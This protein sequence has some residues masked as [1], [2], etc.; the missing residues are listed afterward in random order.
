MTC[1]FTMTRRRT[2]ATATGL[3]VNIMTESFHLAKE[4]LVAHFE[5]EYLTQ[6]IA[7]AGS[8]MSKAARLASIDR[9]TL[10]RLMEKHGFRRDEFG[11]A[12]DE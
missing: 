9:T 7:R 11:G 3:P 4:K 5:K 12:G 1:R 8:N 10:Y 6:L 2:P